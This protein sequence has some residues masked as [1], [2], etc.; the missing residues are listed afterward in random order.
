MDFTLSTQF[1]RSESSLSPQG[2]AFSHLDSLP[3][4][5]LVIWTGGFVFSS[6]KKSYGVLANCSLCGAEVT[7][8][9]STG[10]VCL[11]LSAEVCVI[12]QALCLSRQLH[13]DCHFSSLFLISD[14]R[15]FFATFSSPPSFFLSHHPWHIWQEL[16]FLS[17]FFTIR[18]YWFSGH[19][20]L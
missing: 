9:Y 8:F 12:L 10:S 2:A 3:P 15:S 13:Q 7:L 19:S 20:F 6:H 14:S 17:F 18:L 5:N 11:S 16:S 1:S 4:H